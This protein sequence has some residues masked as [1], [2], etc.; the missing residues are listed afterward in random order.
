LKVKRFGDTF[1]GTKSFHIV[2]NLDPLY[3]GR[4]YPKPNEGTLDYI[5]ELPNDFLIDPFW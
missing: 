5:H 1:A 3:E 4:L 2:H